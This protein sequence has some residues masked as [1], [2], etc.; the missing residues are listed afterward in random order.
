[1]KV[2]YA[3]IFLFICSRLCV[4]S[5]YASNRF[6]IVHFSPY[7]HV[8]PVCYRD[9]E[10]LATM[11]GPLYKHTLGSIRCLGGFQ[12]GTYFF[13]TEETTHKLD[14]FFPKYEPPRVLQS[15]KEHHESTEDKP[16]YWFRA[17]HV[18]GSPW[19][20]NRVAEL[21]RV[22]LLC[23]FVYFVYFFIGLLFFPFF[24]QLDRYVTFQYERL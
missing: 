8:L 14:D 2:D 22:F 11:L 21:V 6:I 19:K 10:I 17:Y 13:S 3:P 20:L 5:M 12:M 1:M 4:F 9:T 24:L 23:M 15:I 7:L 18:K 16:S